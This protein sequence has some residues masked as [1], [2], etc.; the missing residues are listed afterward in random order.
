VKRGRIRSSNKKETRSNNL[1]LHLLIRVS[2][3]AC[4]ILLAALQIPVQKNRLRLLRYRVAKTHFFK[5][6]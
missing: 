1:Y 4:L 5:S 3:L 2:I 6:E